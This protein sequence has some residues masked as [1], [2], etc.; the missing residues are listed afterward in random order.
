MGVQGI[1]IEATDQVIGMDIIAKGS[2]PSLFTIME[3]GLGKKTPVTQFPLQGRAGQGVKLAKV[4]PKTGNV[5]VAQIIPEG[6][7]EIIITSRKGQIVKLSLTSVPK[8]SRDTQGVIL[9]R[10]SDPNDKVTS[11]TC[12]GAVIITA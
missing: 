10:F 6:C 5:T 11:A 4:T 8:L 1:K 9:M 3:N 2:N 12:V 7:E